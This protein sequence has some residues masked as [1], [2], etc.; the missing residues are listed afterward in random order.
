MAAPKGN[1]FG[2]G[3]KGGPGNPPY[4]KTPEQMAVKI[5]MY[6]A[7]FY[8][9]KEDKQPNIYTA[10]PTVTGLALFLGFC[11]RASLYDYRDKDD[12]NNPKYM[13]Y[14]SLIK[15]ALTMVEMNYEQFLLDKNSTGAIFA[16]KNMRW[17]DKQQVDHTSGGKPIDFTP[18]QFVDTP[19]PEDDKD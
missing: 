15:K 3:N 10:N 1:K 7:H 12:G 8:G 9:G 5:D 19:S 14:N 4:Y 17:T 2:L 6:F 11:D 13:G 18:M 16:L